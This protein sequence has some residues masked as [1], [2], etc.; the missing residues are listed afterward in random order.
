MFKI[1]LDICTKNGYSKFH[2]NRNNRKYLKVVATEMNIF[3]WDSIKFAKSE[4]WRPIL[5]VFQTEIGKTVKN[6]SRYLYEE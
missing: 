3:L 5:E 4:N 6:S 2:R 1:V